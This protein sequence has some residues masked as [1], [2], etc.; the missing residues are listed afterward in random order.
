MLGDSHVGPFEVV[1]VSC[2]LSCALNFDRQCCL[3]LWGLA[4]K[5]RSG[6]EEGA[7]LPAILFSGSGRPPAA[8][9]NV[10]PKCME[11]FP[12]PADTT[13]IVQSSTVML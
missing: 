8:A 7:F 13:H 5:G 1:K 10:Q 6:R 4:W 12:V 3:L 9:S 2:Q 11:A